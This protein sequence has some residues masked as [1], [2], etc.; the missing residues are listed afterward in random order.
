MHTIKELRDRAEESVAG[1][2]HF[3][4]L[5]WKFSKP[6]YAEWVCLVEEA[7]TYEL[8]ELCQRRN[9]F[10]DL[11]EDAL[12]A[13]IVMALKSLSLSARGSVVNG[14]SDLT[15]SYDDFV[16][17]GEAKIAR[18]LTT[19]YGGYLQLTQR[20]MPATRNQS[21]GGM[22][23]YCT[24]GQALAILEGWRAALSTQA[25]KANVRDGDVPFTFRSSDVSDSSGTEIDIVHVA[26]PLLYEPKEDILKL[27][28]A[29]LSAGRKAKRSAKSA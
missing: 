27:T 1:K 12:T 17:L 28:N 23:L 10:H 19:V 25:P 20:Y 21:S 6:N 7:I 8:G 14:N 13:V 22:L 2:L 18:D 26:F 16:W 3:Q 11:D 9:D 24:G 15:V 4:L 5:M 29:A